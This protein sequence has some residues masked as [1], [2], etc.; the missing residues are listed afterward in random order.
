MN[1]G[2]VMKKVSKG[3]LIA[4]I[5]G[6]YVLSPLDLLPGKIDDLVVVVF[7]VIKYLEEHQNLKFLENE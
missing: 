3:K 7:T 1:G 4:L 5:V 2:V 6:L